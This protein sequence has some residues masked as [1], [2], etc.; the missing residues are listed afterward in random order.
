[1][2]KCPVCNFDNE[3]GALF[4][5][6]CKSDLGG[7]PMALSESGQNRPLSAE[8]ANAP[9]VPMAPEAGPPVAAVVIGEVAELDTVPLAEAATE[10]RTATE[11]GFHTSSPAGE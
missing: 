6:Q 9:T 4:C 5:E 8:E 10:G 3:D 1:M 11:D 7:E 2:V